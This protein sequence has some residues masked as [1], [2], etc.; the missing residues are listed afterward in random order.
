MTATRR[1][2]PSW[3]GPIV[4]A[5]VALVARL[6]IRPAYWG[7]EE[8]DFTNVNLVW[9]LAQQG[10]AG[11]SDDYPPAY[12]VA[13]AVLYRVFGAVDVST[14]FLTMGGG[15]AL[16]VLVFLLGRRVFSE[17]V[18]W[19][20]ALLACVQ[21]QLLLYSSTPLREPFYAA[22][23]L[24]GVLLMMEA[25]HRSAAVAFVVAALTRYE[26]WFSIVPFH[27]F[28]A[29][30]SSGRPK[31]A[32][33]A[34][35]AIY[36]GL[37]LLWVGYLAW[38]TGIWNPLAGT[39]EANTSAAPSGDRGGAIDWLWGGAR[40]GIT[41]HVWVLGQMLGPVLPLAAIVVS[42]RIWREDRDPDQRLLTGFFAVQMLL[43]A[44]IVVIG[45]F[46][47]PNHP[48]YKK[49][50]V[51]ACA[52]LCLMGAAGVDEFFAALRRRRLGLP[53]RQG[54]LFAIAVLTLLPFGV[55]LQTELRES[56]TKV[57]PQVQ[58]AR[59]IEAE[60][61]RGTAL[62]LDQITLFEVDQ[63]DHGYRLFQ[64]QFLPPWGQDGRRWA[65]GPD[66]LGQFIEENKV[67]LVLWCREE[68]TQGSVIA[69]YLEEAKDQRLGPVQLKIVH[70]DEA[71][72]FRLF[73]VL[74][75]GSGL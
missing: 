62:L 40:V 71:Y 13:A 60:Y 54:L 59:W 23:T 44:A 32:L 57:R 31:R 35:L 24:G 1:P 9:H 14:L 67:D 50:S 63:R 36:L 19:G 3:L 16:V 37:G 15:V 38:F 68:W 5:M 66:D 11:I 26:A 55:E 48:L 17:R 58:I 8:E 6:G 29:A 52:L 18:A 47:P 53:L 70:A 42:V 22:L 46:D 39:F 28:M 4:V 20:A 43:L 61:P 34:P 56:F 21:P 74:R 72:G 25:R 65:A 64:W 12:Y 41:F 2:L 45:Q 7:W 49:W 33:V 27:L 69:P 73:Q 10:P 30:R 75:P 51:L